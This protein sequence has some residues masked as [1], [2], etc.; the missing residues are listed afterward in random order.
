MR[1][2]YAKRVPGSGR[3]DPGVPSRWLF[4]Y[5]SAMTAA[6]LLAA[7]PVQRMTIADE[8]VREHVRVWAPDLISFPLLSPS[9]CQFLIDASDAL[10]EWGPAAGDDFREPTLELDRITPR[11]SEVITALVGRHVNPLLRRLF[12]G[13]HAIEQV[14]TP[15]LVRLDPGPQR[16]DESGLHVER[17][18]NLSFVVALVSDFEGGELRFVRQ[19]VVVDEL[20]VGHALMIPGGPSHPHEQLPVSAGARRTL[21]FQTRS[22]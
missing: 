8:F 17:G 4:H 22:A 15:R 9:F 5:H 7:T 13:M 18:G 14:E 20:P 2:P 12:L 19:R 10:G 6:P 11:L 16:A 1:N 21:A 3:S